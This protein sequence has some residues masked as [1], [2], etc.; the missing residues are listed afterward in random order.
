MRRGSRLPR[1]GVVKLRNDPGMLAM[2]ALYSIAGLIAVLAIMVAVIYTQGDRFDADIDK[3]AAFGT[4]SDDA[5]APAADPEPVE[6]PA[7]AV[8]DAPV[9]A[10]AGAALHNATAP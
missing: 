10:L 2:Q 1:N 7:V 6:G 8:P 9:D 3:D 4:A 5:G